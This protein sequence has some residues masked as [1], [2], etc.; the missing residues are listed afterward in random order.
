MTTDCE[1][2]RQAIVS[3]TL[4][5]LECLY[6]K[7][8]NIFLRNNYILQQIPDSLNLGVFLFDTH[9]DKIV[10]A[11]ER[12]VMSNGLNRRVFKKSVLRRLIFS[13]I[14]PEDAR[15][16]E[17]LERIAKKKGHAPFLNGILRF[18]RHLS[19]V[20]YYFLVTKPEVKGVATEHFRIGIQLKQSPLK[21]NLEHELSEVEYYQK[22]VSSLSMREQEVLQLIV[23]GETDRCIGEVLNI[24]THTS[25]KHRKNILHKL[26]VKNTACLAYMAGK[27]SLFS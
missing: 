21:I 15:R 8:T 27:S 7:I 26:G 18:K 19:Y 1:Q 20:P 6:K 3:A 11:D 9:K 4:E 13:S 12:F 23:K 24:S 25:K 5:N 14:H 2:E 22:L 10:Y 17:V 16:V